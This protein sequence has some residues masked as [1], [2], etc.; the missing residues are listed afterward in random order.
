MVLLLWP[1][2]GAN[3]NRC[4]GEKRRELTKVQDHGAKLLQ[5]EVSPKTGLNADPV[6]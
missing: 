1:V 2:S 3:A 6:P 5:T 4:E